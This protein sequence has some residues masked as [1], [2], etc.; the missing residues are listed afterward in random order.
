MQPE[1][2]VSIGTNEQPRTEVASSGPWEGR[3]PGDILE[4]CR[5]YLLMAANKAVG[6]DLRVKVAPSDLVQETIL[7]AVKGFENFEGTTERELLGWLTKI[8]SL[9]IVEAARRYRRQKADMGREVSIHD[10]AREVERSLSQLDGTPSALAIAQ[11]EEERLKAAMASLDSESQQ[12][13]RMRNWEQLTFTEIGRRLGLS[14][15]AVR[16][17][18]GKAIRELR[19]YLRGG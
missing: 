11:E 18:W 14:E 9:R 19:R 3:S 6:S 10:E 16:K 8:L 13:V 2:T 1:L 4:T 17:R 7:A 5:A 15:S 12:L